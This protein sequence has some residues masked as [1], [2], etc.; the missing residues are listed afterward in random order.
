MAT[1]EQQQPSIEPL[2]RMRDA[3]RAYENVYS[4]LEK[5]AEL[6]DIDLA[7]FAI[8]SERSGKDAIGPVFLD[9]ANRAKMLS[10]GFTRDEIPIIQD[11][12]I[13]AG[14][15]RLG[16]FLSKTPMSGPTKDLMRDVGER[17]EV[18]NGYSDVVRK[19]A[20]RI[21]DARKRSAME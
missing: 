21:S 1:P 20:D 15:Y 7:T 5:A 10:A 17:M 6:I 11:A 2:T 14:A 8:E 13:V 19:A 18:W 12:A 3:Q 16:Y 4:A 9:K